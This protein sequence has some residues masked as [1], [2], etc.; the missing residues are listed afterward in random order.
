MRA[1]RRSGSTSTRVTVQKPSR[2]SSISVRMMSITSSRRNSPI[3]CVRR[4]MADL[5]VVESWSREV[6][7]K[8]RSSRLPD[9]SPSRLRASYL[10]A[11][12]ELDLIADL[13]IV[14]AV[15]AETALVTSRHFADV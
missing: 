6:E 12:E 14:E 4:V 10:F 2:G 13:E 7:E 3:C 15:Q 8:I 1:E 5:R 9:F 11:V